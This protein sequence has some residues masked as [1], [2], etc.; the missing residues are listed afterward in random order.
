MELDTLS[1][2][3][4][5]IASKPRFDSKLD[6]PEG[7]QVRGARRLRAPSS[8]FLSG[9]RSG[10]RLCNCKIIVQCGVQVCVV[11]TASLPWQTGTAVNPLLRASYLAHE[12]KCQVFCAALA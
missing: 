9:L 8:V 10:S 5:R 6:E 3:M 4:K 7:R 11:T 12:T 1:L 2:P